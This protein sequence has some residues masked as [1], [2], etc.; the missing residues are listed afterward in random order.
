MIDSSFV[1]LGSKS[2]CLFLL[3]PEIVSFSTTYVWG[4]GPTVHAIPVLTRI[5]VRDGI[6]VP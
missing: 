2:L 4:Y 5:K 1:I 6:S 3:P